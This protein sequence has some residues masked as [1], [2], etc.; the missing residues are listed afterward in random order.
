MCCVRYTAMCGSVHSR[1]SVFVCVSQRDEI[2]VSIIVTYRTE[3]GTVTCSITQNGVEGTLFKSTMKLFL[4]LHPSIFTFLSM[5]PQ[6]S[7]CL[8]FSSFFSL[9]PFISFSVS[10]L[11][12]RE[13]FSTSLSISFSNSSLDCMGNTDRK[14]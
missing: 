13:S 5:L 4:N 9:F 12:T 11:K 6:L 2:R 1:V 10:Y 7:L 8:S 3:Y 14:E